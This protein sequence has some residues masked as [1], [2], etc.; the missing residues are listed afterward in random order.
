MSDAESIVLLFE[1]ILRLLVLGFLFHISRQMKEMTQTEE[2]SKRSEFIKKFYLPTIIL[3][4]IVALIIVLGI[5]KAFM[6]K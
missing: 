2:E 4:I 1:I 5:P 6:G 3:I